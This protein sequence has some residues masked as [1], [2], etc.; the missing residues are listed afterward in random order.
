MSE[1]RVA[2]MCYGIIPKTTRFARHMRQLLRHYFV[3][4]SL[5]VILQAHAVERLALPCCWQCNYFVL[6]V[7]NIRCFCDGEHP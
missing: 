7:G 3:A 2:L 6:R 5:I 4:F 1:S